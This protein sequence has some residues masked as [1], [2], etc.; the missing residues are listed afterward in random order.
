MLLISNHRIHLLV[1]LR[2]PSHWFFLFLSSNLWS[3]SFFLS[4]YPRHGRDFDKIKIESPDRPTDGQA[5]RQ[6]G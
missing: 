4:V 6:A 1:L 5:G 3:D 2:L